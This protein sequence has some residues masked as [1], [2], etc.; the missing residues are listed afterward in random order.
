MGSVLSKAAL[1]G[2]AAIVS[3]TSF[4]TVSTASVVMYEPFQYDVDTRLVGNTNPG[5]GKQWLD[6]GSPA[7]PVP[8]S[9]TQKI[10]SG[11]LHVLGTP[12]ALG[13]SLSMPNSPNGNIVRIELPNA[14]GYT[15]DTASSTG[16]AP[17]GLFLSMTVKVLQDTAAAGNSYFAGFHLGTGSGGM[18]VSNGYAGMIYLRPDPGNPTNYNFGVAKNN[19]AGSV[20]GWSTES[21]A[22]GGT[23]VLVFQY[24]FAT[25]AVNNDDTANLWV[26]PDL[27]DPAP[28]ASATTSTGADGYV[29]A[30]GPP[31][32]T[33]SILRSV[34][35]RSN[36]TTPSNLQID[37]LRVATS[38][39]E[40]IP[41][42]ASLGAL[43]LGASALIRR[44]RSTGQH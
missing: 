39:A 18:S 23:A 20:I 14:G 9:D 38:Y 25:A 30:G 12:K 13:D 6:P 37:E 10:M 1:A 4:A 33:T 26:N 7:Q 22:P 17:N 28:A 42:P 3:A 36:S 5:T 27:N 15:Y 19:A 35:F 34:Y 29:T 11:N 43:A 16:N 24:K 21:I 40:V 41:E 44:R 8:A 2:V 32:V 31:P